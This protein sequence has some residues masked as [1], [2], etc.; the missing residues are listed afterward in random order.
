MRLLKFVVRILFLAFNCYFQNQIEQLLA[1]NQDLLLR[2]RK[3]FDQAQSIATGREIVDPVDETWMMSS[4][5][6]TDSYFSRISQSKPVESK[7]TKECLSNVYDNVHHQS[8][9]QESIE[10]IAGKPSVNDNS[11]S[12]V[13]QLSHE[14]IQHKNSGLQF[15]GE[16]NGGISRSFKDLSKIGLEDRRIDLNHNANRITKFEHGEEENGA[17]T[18]VPNMEHST[19]V[20]KSLLSKEMMEIFSEELN[21]LEE[22]RDRKTSATEL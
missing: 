21:E 4:F 10:L 19:T 22:K 12:N 15:I 9:R 14:S 20:E 17:T 18:V 13:S 1:Q 3:L 5:P 2:I 8:F 16:R 6:L 11:V 7:V